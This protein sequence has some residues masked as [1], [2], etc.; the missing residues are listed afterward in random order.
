MRRLVWIADGGGA[1]LTSY[2][3]LSS[4]PQQWRIP[5]EDLRF[6]AERPLLWEH[7]TVVVTHGLCDRDALAAIRAYQ[8]GNGPAPS[9]AQ[10]NAALW[11]RQLPTERLDPHKWHVSGHTAHKRARIKKKMACVQIDSACVFERRLSAWC[12]ETEEV[13]SVRNTGY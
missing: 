10:V 2:G 12:A 5:A 9:P 6:F 1:T 13:I 8:A 3:C 4:D 7:D 11:S